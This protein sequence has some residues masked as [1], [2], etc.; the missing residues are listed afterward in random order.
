MG[1]KQIGG[2]APG[3]RVDE[4]LAYVP[5][6]RLIQGVFPQL[7]VGENMSVAAMR[8]LCSGVWIRRSEELARNRQSVRDLRIKTQGLEQRVTHLSGGNQQKV[9]L[10]RWLETEPSLLILE[11]PTQGVD[12]GAKGEI[13]RIVTDLAKRGVTCFWSVRR[14]RSCWRSPTAS[15]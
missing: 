12:V 2:M 4:G 6:D 8:K 1:G 14:S 5:A 13:H 10:A 15:V 11:E 3:S 7:S 9:M